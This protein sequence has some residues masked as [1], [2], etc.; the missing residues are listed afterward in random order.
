MGEIDIIAKHGDTLVFVEVR[1]RAP[2]ALVSAEESVTPIKARRLRLAVRHYL[3]WHDISEKVPIR[4]DL[5]VVRDSGVIFEVI[6][7]IIEFA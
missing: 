5:C 4:V 7:G 6:P 2:L 1:Y 3:A